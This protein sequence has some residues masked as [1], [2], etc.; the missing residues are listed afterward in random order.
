MCRFIAY[1]GEP[2]L[3]ADLLY[4]PRH[5]LVRQSMSAEQMSQTFNADGFGIGFYTDDQPAPCVMRSTVPAWANRGLENLAYRVHSRVVFGHVR[6]ASH[7]LPVQDTNTHPFSNGR[8]QFMHNGWIGS[9][10]SIK[11]ALQSSLGDAAWEAI[12]GTTDSEHAFALV[13]DELGGPGA[14]VTPADLR[15]AVVRAIARIRELDV[16]TGSPRPMVCNFAITDGTATVVSRFA[17]NAAKP[18]SLFYSAGDSY[19]VHGDDCDMV[20]SA[21]GTYGAMMVASEPLTRQPEDW[22]EI[23]DN[24]TI[25]IS[26]DNT[27]AVEPIVL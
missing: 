16:A 19:R 20:P 24:H 8:Y 3:I 2:V 5:S 1:Q 22:V 14:G 7:G 25:T 26:P 13:I 21:D 27:V 23:P 18:A 15:A 11:R 12:E 4:R 6:A 9:F 10:R 17:A